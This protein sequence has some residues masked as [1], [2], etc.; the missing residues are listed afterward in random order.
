MEVQH[1]R[2]YAIIALKN[3]EVPDED[4][5]KITFDYANL[6]KKQG[7]KCYCGTMTCRNPWYTSPKSYE[8][9]FQQAIQC[10]CRKCRGEHGSQAHIVVEKLQEKD[11]IAS[12]S[13][14]MR[15]SDASEIDNLDESDNYDSDSDYQEVQKKSNK[16][17]TRTIQPSANEMITNATS[18]DEDDEQ[19]ASLQIKSLLSRKTFH[20][21]ECNKLVK[22]VHLRA[23][24]LRSHLKKSDLSA[25]T[26]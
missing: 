11:T 9:T 18:E 19:D 25:R 3:I 26:N 13:T 22:Q 17:K 14:K 5:V 4:L 23:N 2:R 12:K 16:K 6:L 24:I 8:E 10:N 21:E 7:Q 1:Q 20:K 15:Y